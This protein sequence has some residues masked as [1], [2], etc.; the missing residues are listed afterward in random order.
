MCGAAWSSRWLMTQLI[1]IA[2]KVLKSCRSVA[3]TNEDVI[4]KILVDHDNSQRQI[5]KTTYKTMF[6]K[7]RCK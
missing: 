6:G 7:V 5:L 2:Q 3:G 1:H 4:I